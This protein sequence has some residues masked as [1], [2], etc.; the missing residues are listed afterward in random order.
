MAQ[1][2]IRRVTVKR[3]DNKPQKKLTMRRVVI[4]N[5]VQRLKQDASAKRR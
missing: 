2:N 4:N 1:I 5:Q 3:K